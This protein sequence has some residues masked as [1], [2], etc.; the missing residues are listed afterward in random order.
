LEFHGTWEQYRADKANLFRA[1]DAHSHIKPQSGSPNPV[2]AFGVV[3]ADDPSAAYF[4]ASARKP[5]FSF[6]LTGQPADFSIG[7]IDSQTCGNSYTVDI[8][9]QTY[10]IDDKLPGAF[11]AANV[12]AACLTVMGLLGVTMDA[13]IPLIPRLLPVRGR[14]SAVNAGQDFEVT[15][16]YAHTP[17]SFAVIFPPLRARLDK[18]GG[19]IITLFG[20]G[21]ERDT[22]K[23]PQQGKVAAQWSDFI[24]LT[25]EDPRG[26]PPL[27]ILRQI[28]AGIPSG[29]SRWTE[30]K[31]F[32]LI[33]DR[34]QAIKKAFSL[35][36]KGDL[37]LLLGKGHENSIIYADRTIPY[38]EF[39][40]AQGALH[41][42]QSDHL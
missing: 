18:S 30:N 22:Q 20:S 17:S 35:A 34:F 11:N 29:D 26:E 40:A 12:A 1:L 6:S 24:I 9:G 39:A 25:D 23:R 7:Q 37:V 5:V 10:H 27:D 28:A 36:K 14:M 15:I 8:A 31:T 41:E 4:T 3:N 42:I 38:D 33:P 19:R 21:G 16:D 2:N 13:L 32:F